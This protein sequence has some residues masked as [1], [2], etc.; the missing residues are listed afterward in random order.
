MYNKNMEKKG[1]LSRTK[2]RI[3]TVLPMTIG[4]FLLFALVIYL[5]VI[6]GRSVWVNYKSNKD[7][8]IQRQEIAR[9]QNDVDMLQLEIAYYKTES[10][11]EKEARAKLGYMA[12]GEKV[13]SLS[14]D[15][16]EDKVADSGKQEQAIKTPNY[17]L[18]ISYFFN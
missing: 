4:N 3:E 9:L 11:K 14:A 18:W 17:R 7:L 10:F 15:K 13:L 2:D 12:P 6:V 8:D 16:P 1:F 5:I